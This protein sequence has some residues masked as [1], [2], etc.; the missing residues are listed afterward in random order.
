MADFTAH[1]R[2][3]YFLLR[4]AAARSAFDDFAAA[5]SMKVITADE[6]PLR[7]GLISEND[8]GTWPSVI[9]DEDSEEEIEMEVPA[10]ISQWL[11]DGAVAIFMEVGAEKMRYLNGYAVAINNQ[12][13]ERTVSLNDI[14]ERAAD[15][16]AD[17][18][19]A[20]Y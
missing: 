1:A 20:S 12:G 8:H 6:N 11:A 2:S 15:L 9:V 19:A 18:T 3:N 5:A 14:Y 7:V 4:D 16:G 13:E 10:H 17:V